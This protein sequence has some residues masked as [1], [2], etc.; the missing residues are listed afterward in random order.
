MS[1]SKHLFAAVFVIFIFAVSPFMVFDAYPSA[2]NTVKQSFSSLSEPF[3]ADLFYQTIENSVYSRSRFRQECRILYS[4][5]QAAL[6]KRET[7]NFYYIKD[8]DGFLHSG[9]LYQALDSGTMSYA[10][11]VARLKEA[12]SG[13]PVLFV[14]SPDR[15]DYGRTRIQDG[16]PVDVVSPR[17]MDELLLNLHFLGVDTLDLRYS[18]LAEWPQ[19]ELFYRT[20]RRWTTQA[21]FGAFCILVEELEQKYSLTLDPRRFYRDP[22]NYRVVTYPESYLGDMGKSVGIPFSGGPEDFSVVLPEFDTSFEVR[23]G[24]RQEEGS[25]ET[26]VLNLAQLAEPELLSRDSYD[27]YLDGDRSTHTIKN[28]GAKDA[29]RLL[30]IGDS[31]FTPVAAYLATVFSEVTMLSVSA[32]NPEDIEQHVLDHSYDYILIA[33][34][35]AGMDDKAFSFFKS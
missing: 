2:V 34:N 9:S 35:S 15:Y 5:V 10:K 17:N 20:N 7:R 29:P 1:L 18:P 25:F 19:E 11:R 28:S 21:A 4:H 26:S 27:V 3:E 23:S 31:F 33:Y 12:V 14:A 8:L 24:S 16:Y 32:T 30:M 22:D 6:Q 13:T